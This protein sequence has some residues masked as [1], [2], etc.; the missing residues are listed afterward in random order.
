MVQ[1]K[2]VKKLFRMTKKREILF[3]Q[4]KTM[5]DSYIEGKEFGLDI[6]EHSTKRS[7]DEKEAKRQEYQAD[8]SRC[9]EAKDMLSIVR[10][11]QQSY[12]LEF[13]LYEDRGWKTEWD[14]PLDVFE[15]AIETIVE[16]LENYKK[17]TRNPASRYD[18]PIQLLRELLVFRKS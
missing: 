14:I 9:Q 16:I 4:T 15:R 17:K 13:W 5:I 12:L 6:L 8:I 3:S 7:V 2:E 11:H 10:L 18:E 1:A